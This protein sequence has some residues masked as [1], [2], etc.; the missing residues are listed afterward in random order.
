MPDTEDTGL[1]YLISELGKAIEYLEHFPQRRPKN[2][3]ANAQY[4]AGLYDMAV[5]IRD[6]AQ[7]EWDWQGLRAF[8]VG[9]IPEDQMPKHGFELTIKPKQS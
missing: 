5:W 7:K 4:A 1:T 9:S 6:N 2:K 8:V 3:T